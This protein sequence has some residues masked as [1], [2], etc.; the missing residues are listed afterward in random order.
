MGFKVN[1]AACAAGDQHAIGSGPLSVLETDIYGS[2][3]GGDAE[4]ASSTQA[5]PAQ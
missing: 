1:Q 5:L 4:A 2:H 3:V